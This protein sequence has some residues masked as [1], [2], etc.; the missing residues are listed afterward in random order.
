[1]VL[2]EATLAKKTAYFPK[3]LFKRGLNVD[4]EKLFA[5]EE[6]WQKELSLLQKHFDLF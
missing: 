2:K 1:M 5:I 3:A 6:G 4:L